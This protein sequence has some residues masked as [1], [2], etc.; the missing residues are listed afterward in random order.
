MRYD[1]EKKTAVA[2]VAEACRLCRTVQKNLVSIETISKEDR[3]P[4]TVADFGAQAIVSYILHRAFPDIPL[5]AEEHS[6]RLV[7]PENS[8]LKQ[9]VVENVRQVKPQLDETSILAAIDRGSHRGGANGRFWCLDPVD[10][11]KGFL[12]RDQYAVALALIDHGEVVLG[13]LGCPNLPLDMEKPEDTAG[14]LVVAVRNEGAFMSPLESINERLNIQVDDIV[15]PTRAKFC[16]SVESGHSSHGDA[17]Q[18]A[19]LLSVQEPPVRI[20][21]QCK[22]AVV[23]RGDASIYLRLPTAGI[24]IDEPDRYVEKNWDHAAGSIIIEE[25]GGSVSDVYGKKL[26]FSRGRT[27]DKNVGVIVTNGLIHDRVLE[28]VE[29]VLGSRDEG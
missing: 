16:E 27:L 9:R 19:A 12:R 4:V 18:V 23:A 8:I 3:S 6:N 17:A 14:C 10:G 1:I 7:R 24:D 13:V 5:M 22:Y 2:A 11:T 26:D 15:D 21:S 29:Q 28:A 20:D 25:A